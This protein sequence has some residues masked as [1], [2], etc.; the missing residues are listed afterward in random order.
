M[1]ALV[2]DFQTRLKRRAHA[3]FLRLL[4]QSSLQS[5]GILQV[6]LARLEPPA[7]RWKELLGELPVQK[8]KASQSRRSLDGQPV[9]RVWIS[10]GRL[11]DLRVVGVDLQEICEASISVAAGWLPEFGVLADA[12]KEKDTDGGIE[13]VEVG[14]FEADAQKWIPLRRHSRRVAASGRC[15]AQPFALETVCDFSSARDGRVSCLVDGR[16]SSSLCLSPSILLCLWW[17]CSALSERPL[18][19]RRLF[20]QLCLPVIPGLS[21]NLMLVVCVN[22]SPYA[23]LQNPV[24]VSKPLED[25]IDVAETSRAKWKV[26]QKVRVAKDFDKLRLVQLKRRA[27]GANGRR[28]K[29]R[30]TAS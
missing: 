22:G 12:C 18:K 14:D 11:L 3:D 1:R 21:P 2:K 23:A 27:A 25:Q 15:Q 6:G 16:V 19:L 26:K 30:H 20:V 8:T 10:L 29:T 7:V 4:S 24:D 17:C 9:Q 13:K 5:I 28:L